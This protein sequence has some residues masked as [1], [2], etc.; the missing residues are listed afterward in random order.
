MFTDREGSGEEKES[1]ARC[2]CSAR[3]WRWR[4]AWAG[5][6]RVESGGR[7]LEVAAQAKA[8]HSK[9]KNVI[10]LLGDGM[11]ESEITIARN[12]QSARPAG[13]RAS[14]RRR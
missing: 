4:R 9:A 13:C 11:G 10:F 5:R 1:A 7:S 14:T 8:S 2:R 12:Y 3:R 6:W